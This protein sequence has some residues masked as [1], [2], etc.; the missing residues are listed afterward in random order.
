MKRHLILAFA[1]LASSVALNAVN[2]LPD[3]DK[4]D[5]KNKTELNSVVKKTWEFYSAIKQPSADALANAGN[6]KF[7][8][9]AGYLYNQFMKIYVVREEV[10]PGDPTRR[11]V[12]RKPTI[13]NAVRS[14]EKQLNKELISRRILI[15]KP[16]LNGK[17]LSQLKIR[18]NFGA[19]ITRVNRSGVDLVASP[20]LQLQMGDRVTIVGSELAVTHAEKVLGNSMK[21]LNHPNLIPIFIGIALGCILGSLPFAFPGIPQPVKLG[22][23]GGP[24]IVSIL[25]SRFGP[26]YKL[27]TYTTM[28]ANL[29]LREIGISIFLA[30]VGLGAGEGFVDTVIHGG[31]YIWV[32]YGVII[33]I[34]PLLITGLVGRY[35][36]KLNYFT[37]IGVLAGSTT[38]PPALAYSNDLTSCDAPAVGYATVYPL[39]M[40]LRVLTA[41]ILILS[42]G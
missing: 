8:Q 34:L 15:T 39:T 38:N 9:E 41:Q 17:T 7:G 12:I 20:Q 40:F 30:C 18:N 14:I 35:Y 31:G 19:N 2:S 6:Y 36:C 24:L 1:L 33:T 3:D 13:Y 16:E 29:M 21:R 37:L 28:S 26:K 11:T 25:I 27:I 32:G 5:N 42:L 22:L 10:V 23:A 4:S